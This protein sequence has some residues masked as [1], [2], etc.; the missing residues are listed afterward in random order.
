MKKF[1]LIYIFLLGI[2]LFL[3]AQSL[4]INELSN[5]PSGAEEYVEFVVTGDIDCHASSIKTID[6]RHWIFDDNNGYFASG[7]GTGIAKGAC[8]FTNDNFWKAIPVG[9]IILI[10][11]DDDKNPDIPDDDLSMSDGNCKLV[12]P[13]SS[14]LIDRQEDSPNT[15]DENYATSGWKN[16]GAWT[17]VSMN[18]SNDSYQIRNINNVSTV[19]HAVSY[20]NNT[21]NTTIYFSGSGAEKVFYF[22]NTNDDDPYKQANWISGDANTDQTPGAPN[23]SKNAN[24]I[25]RLSH[26]C[27]TSPNALTVSDDDTICKGSS[28]I[29][30]ASGGSSNAIYSWNQ[31]LGKGDSKTVSP[32]ENTQ[33]LV[34][35]TDNGWCLDDTVNIIVNDKPVIQLENDLD[36]EKGKKLTVSTSNGT[37]PYSYHWSDN[38]TSSSTQCLTNGEYT[39]TVSDANNCVDT[40]YYKVQTVIDDSLEIPTIFSPNG[41]N[42]NDTWKIKN[43]ASYGDN[44]LDIEIYDRWGTIVFSYHGTC[45]EYD[46]PIN[47]WDGTFKGKEIQ[48]SSFVYIVSI[49]DKA[50]EQGIVSI[51]R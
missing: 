39:L 29:I 4:I 46:N 16:K 48:I 24:W 45:T 37:P 28:T 50:Y 34:T 42:K 7:S 1:N 23:S 27:T 44:T 43:I 20:G 2:P 22:D 25:Y 15:S 35:M 36:C 5:G 33:Y 12:I 9:T 10:Y 49:N 26:Y 3:N 14:T 11:N 40:F 38:E 13:I 18:N 8:R 41:D 21:N 6:L 47:Q 31:A 19:V 32:T 51:I 17:H 30:S